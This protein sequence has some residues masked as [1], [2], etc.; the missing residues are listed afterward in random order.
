MQNL[1]LKIGPLFWVA[2][3]Y[4]NYF[5][6]LKGRFGK[7]SRTFWGTTLGV[8]I[9]LAEPKTRFCNSGLNHIFIIPFPKERRRG[10]GKMAN[11]NS[12]YLYGS[13]C[14]I[15]LK[16]GCNFK[17]VSCLKNIDQYVGGRPFFYSGFL[18]SAMQ[19][20]FWGRTSLEI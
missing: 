10:G 13:E 3:K 9:V 12:N 19:D 5:T 15:Y 18:K 11:S 4:I 16:P 8:K 7:I 20:Q 2:D 6:N 14:L 1:A 17:L